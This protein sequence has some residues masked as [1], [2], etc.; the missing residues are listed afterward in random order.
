LEAKVHAES[1][2]ASNAEKALAAEQAFK[3]LAT[4]SHSETESHFREVSKLK[5]ELEEAQTLREKGE[6]EVKD[7]RELASSLKL[8]LGNLVSKKATIELRESEMQ[9]EVQALRSQVSVLTAQLARASEARTDAAGRKEDHFRAMAAIQE[10]N[11]ALSRKLADVTEAQAGAAEEAEKLRGETEGLSKTAAASGEALAA[12]LSQIA[13]Y[14]TEV[15]ML[16]TECGRL[17]H[18]QA[19]SE[20]REVENL[21]NL[22][23]DAEAEVRRLREEAE[24][25]LSQD[26]SGTLGVDLRL[27]VEDARSTAE[28][29]RKALE[30]EG[31]R[32]RDLE[33]RLAIALAIKSDAES[34]LETAKSAHA[35]NVAE[36][37][38]ESAEQ[39]RA[40]EQRIEE[41]LSSLEE[42]QQRTLS[43]ERANAKAAIAIKRLRNQLQD[44]HKDAKE[45]LGELGDTKDEEITLLQK[46]LNMA[47]AK[48]RDA[49]ETNLE[50]EKKLATS[51]GRESS[52]SHELLETRRLLAEEK[53]KREGLMASVADLET[54]LAESLSCSEGR[55]IEL[56]AFKANMQLAREQVAAAS[57]VNSNLRR[58]LEKTAGDLQRK[59]EALRVTNAKLEAA[60]RTAKDMETSSN[61]IVVK[62]RAHVVSISAQLDSVRQELE[63][64]QKANADQMTKNIE[65]EGMLKLA[66]D[67]KGE[68]E[69]NLRSS[70]EE[71][72]RLRGQVSAL[73][74]NRKE[75]KERADD[76]M[77]RGEEG[78][79]RLGAIERDLEATKQ[80][81][82]VLI[83]E[84]EAT[85]SDLVNA[86]RSKRDLEVELSGTVADAADQE[87][88]ISELSASLEKALAEVDLVKSLLEKEMALAAN[89]KCSYESK[90]QRDLAEYSTELQSVRRHAEQEKCRHDTALAAAQET[91]EVLK[92]QLDMA[93]A[94]VH[95]AKEKIAS[96]ECELEEAMAVMMDFE[97]DNK[98]LQTSLLEVREQLVSTQGSVSDLEAS[99]SALEDELR[100][101]AQTT[102]KLES[103]ASSLRS[104]AA[105]QKVQLEE[106]LSE[107]N[108]LL[109]KLSTNRLERDAAVDEIQRLKVELSS[110][111]D[112]LEASRQDVTR[113]ENALKLGEE[114]Y[115]RT[116]DD[117]SAEREQ[118]ASL[119]KES[120]NQ[121]LMRERESA[122]D[123]QRAIA[124]I[125]ERNSRA[126]ALAKQRAAVAACKATSDLRELQVSRDDILN[127]CDEMARDVEHWKA[128]ADELRGEAAARREA[129]ARASALERA[130]RLLVE[131]LMGANARVPALESALRESKAEMCRLK[132]LNSAGANDRKEEDAARSLLERTVAEL[133]VTAESAKAAEQGASN[134]AK[135]LEAEAHRMS[136]RIA[137]LEN[138]VN[139]AE[140]EVQTLRNQLEQEVARSQGLVR[141]AKAEA[142]LRLAESRNEV[143]TLTARLEHER[144]AA[145][146]LAAEV[147]RAQEFKGELVTE[148]Q[149][150]HA[151]EIGGS[152][153]GARS[154]TVNPI[155]PSSAMLETASDLYALGRQ[156]REKD[157]QLLSVVR[158]VLAQIRSKKLRR[159]E[160]SKQSTLALS[161]Q[162][163]NVAGSPLQARCAELEAIVKEQS[164]ALDEMLLLD[165]PQKSR[166]MTSSPLGESQLNHN[167]SF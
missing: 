37:Q 4:K 79:L 131:E 43:L 97:Q 66:E 104:T 24:H 13:A 114:R 137:T 96:L 142:T 154:G 130:R 161:F 85:Q 82:A 159:K 49:M 14:K 1:I 81:V 155:P 106:V 113:A 40:Q 103:A 91:E 61:E 147:A 8:E 70:C 120:A 22:V 157:E 100:C 149:S 15:K 73:E 72:E 55:S 67:S 39:E 41:L 56:H 25:R 78:R 167:H 23:R 124:D 99:K 63:L 87:A 51:L 38:A 107:R 5:C 162:A 3:C 33:E 58:M 148:L 28:E 34:C 126:I 118:V 165:P 53:E 65:L 31:E 144:G 95:E 76:M 47:G 6:L 145:Q 10:R 74:E 135:A 7:L 16:R 98:D 121:A 109:E 93:L 101:A 102:G 9:E 123:L 108:T 105:S 146:S 90:Q 86:I 134:R 166:A 2:I 68:L 80:R 17:K 44:A 35:A 27:Q 77:V 75:L 140:H 89:A 164:D 132:E 163:S 57:E 127:R 117:L 36:L 122:A 110:A 29:L 18:A 30:E 83:E 111:L 54:Q 112:A 12:M 150:L 119:Q 62:E 88:K 151:E 32:I 69:H 128:R 160:K 139:E 48:Q 50:L 52:V 60:Q 153:E 11:Q 92:E 19:D 115:C 59:E 138:A 116:L 42:G 156:V 94:E 133:R 26:E 46:E 20:S 143:H 84:Q 64:S 136:R 152:T 71:C 141:D 125:E 21:R 158:S 45:S 129:E